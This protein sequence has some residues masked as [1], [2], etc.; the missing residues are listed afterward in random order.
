MA[1]LPDIS[2][3]FRKQASNIIVRS[4]RGNVFL[5]IRDSDAE[6]IGNRKYT[7]LAD[8]QADESLYSAANATA[9][10]DALYYK[11]FIVHVCAIGTSDAVSVALAKIEGI[12]KTA[13]ITVAG[14]TAADSTAIGTWVKA[15]EVL[16]K[17]YKAVVYNS[18]ANCRHVVNLV[19]T[20]VKYEDGRETTDASTFTPSLAAILAACN[21]KRGA[22]NF[23]CESLKSVTEPASVSTAVEAGGLVLIN[24]DDGNV[25]IAEGINSLTTIT[26]D[27][28]EDM[29]LIE[30]IEGMDLIYDDIVYTFRNKFMGRYRNSRGNQYKFISDVKTYFASLVRVG[31]LSDTVENTVDIDVEAQRAAWEAYGIDPSGWSDDE[32]KDHPYKRTMFLTGSITMLQSIE[33][34]RFGIT[35][36]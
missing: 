12:V 22:T 20:A 33:S 29:K 18:A 30:I 25:R 11:P 6:T 9:I 35:L 8:F 14:I 31:L 17:S 34:L 32:V 19:N 5:I 1:L 26:S 24:D 23:L 21:I 15:Q 2:V 3:F 16:N 27:E 13:W 7:S 4:E 28:S 10:K 36:C